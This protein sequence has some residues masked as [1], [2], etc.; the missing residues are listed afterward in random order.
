MRD[1]TITRRNARYRRRLAE[2][3]G[4]QRI[5]VFVPE[6]RVEELKAFA[7]RLRDRPRSNPELVN[8]RAKLLYHRL[9][10]RR[11]RHRPSLV[12]RAKDVVSKPPFADSGRQIIEEWRRLLNGPAPSL[13]DAL[14]GRSAES[15]RLRLNSPFPFVDELKIDDEELRRR[16]WRV[17]KRAF[18]RATI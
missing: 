18:A 4:L 16:L 2:D 17:A 6:D 11:L 5:E 8:D 14:I 12:A 10:A 1:R 13:I 15:R 7:R 9:V 3:R